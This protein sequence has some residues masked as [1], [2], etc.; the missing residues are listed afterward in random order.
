[1]NGGIGNGEYK[2]LHITGPA[3]LNCLALSKIVCFQT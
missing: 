1:M 3:Q 2:Q